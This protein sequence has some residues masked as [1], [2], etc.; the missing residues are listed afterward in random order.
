MWHFTWS[1]IEG[2]FKR[3]V[4]FEKCSLRKMLWFY[5][6]ITSQW[7]IVHMITL[8]STWNRWQTIFKFCSSIQCCILRKWYLS[9]Q[10]RFGYKN[11]YKSC[12][13]LIFMQIFQWNLISFAAFYAFCFRV[14]FKFSCQNSWKLVFLKSNLNPYQNSLNC[15][16]LL[17]MNWRY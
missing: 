4:M 7:D 2:Y 6:K 17:F 12:A 9:R 13:W 10:R 3:F 1:N 15:V 16:L 14:L 5:S 8:I 11:Q